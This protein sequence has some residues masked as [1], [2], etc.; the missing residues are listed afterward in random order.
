MARFADLFCRGG[1]LSF[2]ALTTRR[3]DARCCDNRGCDQ[4]CPGSA[5]PVG[6]RE[7]R[8]NDLVLTPFLAEKHRKVAEPSA[9]APR[10]RMLDRD[11]GL[12]VRV[13]GAIPFNNAASACRT[14]AR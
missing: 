2:H 9:P 14:D 10:A 13:P 6:S 3:S 7:Y 1:P 5:R 11:P 8:V 12:K 4:L